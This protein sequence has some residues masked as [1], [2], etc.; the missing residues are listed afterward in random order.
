V[1]YKV[2]ES[3]MDVSNLQDS[4]EAYGVHIE[5]FTDSDADLVREIRAEAKRH[6]LQLS[7]ADCCC[8]ATAVRLQVPAVV[9]DQSWKALDLSIDVQPFR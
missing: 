3:G 6:G 4:L 8:L 7:L 5:P 1:L 2:A 9:S